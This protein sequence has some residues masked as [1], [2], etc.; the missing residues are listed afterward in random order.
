MKRSLFALLLVCLAC[1]RAEVATDT[2][3]TTGTTD[4]TATQPPPQQ[5]VQYVAIN[6]QVYVPKATIDGWINANPI[7]TAAIAQHA[8]AIWGGMTADS[9]Q[10]LNGTP[11]PVWETWYDSTEVYAAGAGSGP[12]P[13][14]IAEKLKAA[15]P[16]ERKANV[17]RLFHLPHQ[18]LTHGKTGNAPDALGAPGSSE[19][20][21]L[22]FNRFTQEFRDH[23]WANQYYDSNVLTNLNNSWTANTPTQDRTI[24]VFPDRAIMLKPVFVVVSG[25]QPTAVP[26]WN[27]TGT[28]AT[29]DPL[30][31]TSDT[32]KQCVLADPTGKATNAQPLVCNQGNKGETTMPG[33]S[34]QVVPISA[35]PSES[36]FYAIKMTQEEVD[37][38]K[39]LA[40][41]DQ[42]QGAQAGDFALF[43]ASHVSS[44]EIDNWTWQT[45]WWSPTPA[46][47]PSAPP[48]ALSPPATIAKPWNMYVGCT[49]YYMVTPPNAPSG[50][51]LFCYNPYLETDLSGLQNKDMSQQATGVSSNCMTCHRAAAWP[52]NQYAQA[53]LLRPDDP[54]WFAANTK[55]DFAWSMV[56]LAHTPPFV[57]APGK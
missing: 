8:W 40:Q 53:F 24:K 7:D 57:P 34:Y 1:Q 42:L 25:T 15:G 5:Q 33:G 36:G 16:K 28:N 31:P 30:N 29:A 35:T 26:Y 56:N 37:D 9:G 43:V 12:S 39:A 11:L 52:E 51:P 19:A 48:N 54:K 49:A 13:A 45:F 47:P 3:G 20:V 17:K 14:A 32:W 22:T 2:T 18:S 38:M 41:I 50:Q 23:V 10:T 27:G 46:T 55:T 4:T 21:V 6:P 44:R